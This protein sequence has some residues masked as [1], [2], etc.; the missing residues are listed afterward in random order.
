MLLNISK[1]LVFLLII[2]FGYS[3]MTY[4]QTDVWIDET[5]IK[6]AT[7][8]ALDTFEAKGEPGLVILLGNLYNEFDKKPDLRLLE[9]TAV[10]DTIGLVFTML[11]AKDKGVQ[12]E[13][14][15]QYFSSFEKHKN[16]VLRRLKKLGFSE[17]EGDYTMQAWTQTSQKEMERIMDKKLK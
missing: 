2:I 5:N 11:Y 9:K 13:E 7:R 17:E 3:L 12:M 10:I 15:S 1:K 16:R 6:N 14:I 8:I 4:A